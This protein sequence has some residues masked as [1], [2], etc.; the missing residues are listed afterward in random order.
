M[1]RIQ[2]STCST[3]KPTGSIFDTVFLSDEAREVQCEACGNQTFEPAFPP[4]YNNLFGAQECSVCPRVDAQDLLDHCCGQNCEKLCHTACMTTAPALADCPHTQRQTFYLCHH[5]CEAK[6]QVICTLCY[7]LAHGTTFND[8][9]CGEGAMT[10]P[11]TL[12]HFPTLSNTSQHFPTLS[13]TQAYTHTTTNA[14]DDNLTV[15]RASY[16]STTCK[17]WMPTLTNIFGPNSPLHTEVRTEAAVCIQTA[18]RQR[19]SI[20]LSTEAAPTQE[21]Q[22]LREDKL[23]QLNQRLHWILDY[24]DQS[25]I[26]LKNRREAMHICREASTW[27]ATALPTSEIANKISHIDQLMLA[28]VQQTA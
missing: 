6:S 20:P 3:L 12:Q 24:A 13:N 27:L 17:H 4:D 16:T 23:A 15:Q 18:W 10:P 1:H 8:N 22:Q 19:S 26:P 5:C 7:V 14:S 9:V 28:I 11:D 2:C 21:Q 25:H